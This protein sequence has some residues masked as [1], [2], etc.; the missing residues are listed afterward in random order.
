M[1]LVP[2][3]RERK[4]VEILYRLLGE[5]TPEESVNHRE[6]PSM[7]DHAKFVRS[8]PYQCWYLVEVD[9]S[10]VGCVYITRNRELGVSIFKTCR[11]Q[12][13]AVAALKMLMDKWPGHFDANINPQNEKSIRLFEKLGFA[14]H[15]VV[16]RRQREVPE[17]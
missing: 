4:A 15:Q 3:S 9:K 10:Y 5:R 17:C 2:I 7:Q 14:L 11:Q 1:K 16:Y 6:M 8:N 12:G 13:Y